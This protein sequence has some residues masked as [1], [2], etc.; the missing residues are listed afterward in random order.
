M[1]YMMNDDFSH[2]LKIHLWEKI[3]L[4]VQDL[5]NR[6]TENTESHAH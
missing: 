6:S 5:K 4:V 2:K 3:I 1:N